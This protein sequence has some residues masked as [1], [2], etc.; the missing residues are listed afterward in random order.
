MSR[1]YRI[2]SVAWNPVTH[3][4]TII[5]LDACCEERVH[6]V[7]IPAINGGDGIGAG[8]TLTIEDQ[9]G[10]I[11]LQ[12]LQGNVTVVDGQDLCVAIANACANV[13]CCNLAA[14]SGF[15]PET[16]L[17]TIAQTNGP[18]LLIELTGVGGVQEDTSVEATLGG[19]V[20]SA[21]PATWPAAKP[22]TSQHL[23]VYREDG[24]LIGYVDEAGDPHPLDTVSILDGDQVE[25]SWNPTVYVPTS[26]PAEAADVD[27]LTAHLAGIDQELAAIYAAIAAGGGGGGAGGVTWESV[28]QK[29]AR[30]T[31]GIEAGYR[32][33]VRSN[34]LTY[35]WNGTSYVADG[36]A[37]FANSSQWAA[38]S[39]ME[40]NQIV[41]VSNHKTGYCWT[42]AEG[43][44]Q[45]Y[46]VTEQPTP[47]PI[48][49]AGFIG[50]GDPA[51]LAADGTASHAATGETL[52]VVT[53]L[54]TL[55]DQA[56][57]T[58][59]VSGA[60]GA[61]PTVTDSAA[62]IT[63]VEPGGVSELFTLDAIAGAIWGSITWTLTVQDS[64]AN[65]DVLS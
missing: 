54:F 27:D 62:I 40:P 23:M 55:D 16:N 50:T 31:V 43:W 47:L 34:R 20:D 64:G 10:D 48:E 60:P 61:N 17:L 18:S 26:G 53:W 22:S 2:K 41:H 1:G 44:V 15:N 39:E 19:A 3:Q 21:D 25:I 4:L 37:S 45:I 9:T 57:R 14:G 58:V 52:T 56:G 42:S 13:G 59:E 6:I 38:M 8:T 51:I 5:E 32:A 46:G 33:F 24:A 12:D 28:A 29:S 63:A 30:T 11:T 65:I 7:T 49:A 35:V 36:L